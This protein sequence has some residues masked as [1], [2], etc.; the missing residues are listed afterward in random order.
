MKTSRQHYHDLLDRAMSAT[1]QGESFLPVFV[2][3]VMQELYPVVS[4]PAMVIHKPDCAVALNA[5][6]ACSCG[7]ERRGKTRR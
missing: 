3:M 7:A 2:G 6:H 1:R 5:R 4:D